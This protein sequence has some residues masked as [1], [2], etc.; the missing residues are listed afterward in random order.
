MDHPKLFLFDYLSNVSSFIFYAVFYPQVLYPAK[1]DC[2]SC[3][4]SIGYIAGK[5][6]SC[7]ASGVLN[8]LSCL[9]GVSSVFCLRDWGSGP[10]T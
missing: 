5:K 8:V 1:V 4:R 6:H 9:H 10:H 2:D 3:Q 7:C